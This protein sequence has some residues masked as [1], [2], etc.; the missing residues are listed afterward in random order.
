[1]IPAI[2]L[3]QPEQY[4]GLLDNLRE[5][6]YI[7]D[8]KRRIRYWNPAAEQISGFTSRQVIGRC[9][10]DNILVHVDEGGCQLCQHACPLEHT[11]CDRQSRSALVYL[12]HRQGHRV[13]VQVRCEAILDERDQVVGAVEIFSRAIAERVLD[14]EMELLRREL[15]RDA[16]TEIPNRRYMSRLLTSQIDQARRFDQPFGLLFID[17]DH[18]KHIND[19][20]GHEAG[21]RTL[22]T[23]ARTISGALR[24]H[25]AF[26]R[27]GGEEFLMTAA[28]ATARQLADLARRLGMLVRTTRIHI[29]Q[30]QPL[31]ITTS[32][33]GTWLS[34]EDD[35][36]TLVAR[37]DAAMYQAKHKGR[38]RCVIQPPPGVEADLSAH[39]V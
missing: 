28:D 37:A 14:E 3:K 20:Y 36:Q 39:V 33:G 7:V 38:D 17:L 35:I 19:Q 29:D 9:C 34:A 4:K 13:P 21:D 5:G 16:L 12:H 11:M 10:S 31:Q 15:H 30:A 6:L 1:M 26:G 23:I 8:R 24:P 25:D 27:W 2:L 32:I 22:Q 18:F